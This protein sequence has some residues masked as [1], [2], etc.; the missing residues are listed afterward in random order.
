MV[1]YFDL[2]WFFELATSNKIH[3]N[4]LNLHEIKNKTLL[5]FNVD[6]EV[7]GSMFIHTLTC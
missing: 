2:S 7:I 5:D 4:G 1:K 3:V 6:F